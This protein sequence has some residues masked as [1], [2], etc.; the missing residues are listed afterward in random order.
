MRTYLEE[1]VLRCGEELGEHSN[2]NMTLV[3]LKKLVYP[4]VTLMNK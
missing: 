3:G 4:K 1:K 2:S